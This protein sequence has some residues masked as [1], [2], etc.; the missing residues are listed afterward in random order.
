MLITSDPDLMRRMNAVRSPFTRGP[1]YS[2]L[3]LH[4]DIDNITSHVDERIHADLRNRMSPGYSGKENE[5][6]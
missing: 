4:P 1:W 2:A 5:H 3:K 6:M